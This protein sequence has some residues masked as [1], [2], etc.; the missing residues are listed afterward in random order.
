VIYTPH[1]LCGL[2][3]GIIRKQVIRVSE[4]FGYKV[5]KAYLSVEDIKD[6]DE[7]FI[8]NSIASIFPVLRIDNIEF[9]KRSFAEY[10]LS[11]EKF[12]RP[13]SC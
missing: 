5:K 1:I 13:W 11:M 9:K 6:M 3:P 7:C 8:T 2:L 4:E 12:E 10:L